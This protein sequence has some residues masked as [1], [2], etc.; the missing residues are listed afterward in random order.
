MK[1]TI[2]KTAVGTMVLGMCLSASAAAAEG[3]TITILNTKSELVDQFE[4]LAEEY[5]EKTGVNVEVSFT[6]DVVGT[7]LAEKYAAG[8]PYTVMMVDKPDVYDFQEYLLDLSGEKWAADG[9]MEYGTVID[10]ALY[11]FPLMIESVGLL[12]NADAIEAITGEPFV[13]EDYT[14]VEAFKQLLEELKAGGME[15]PVAVNKEDWSLANHFFGQLYSQQGNSA[16]GSQSFVDDLIAGTVSLEENARFQSIMDTFDLLAE[17]NINSSDPLAAE[18]DLNNSYFAEGDVAFWFNGSWATDIYEVTEN[19]GMMPMPQADTADEANTRLICGASKALVVDGS[20]STAEEQQAA[21]DFLNWLAY[22]E[23]GQSFIVD[24]CQMI[25]AF[26]HIEKTVSTP[27]G[28]SAQSFIQNGATEYWYQTIPGDHGT[29]VGASLQ[30]YL[31]GVT[32]RSEFAAEV[33]QY[34]AAQK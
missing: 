25:P 2:C 3:T 34:W 21:K 26:S 24:S 4:A 28:I 16:E 5:E 7:H 12:Y 14:D 6:S 27:L 10:G 18:Y 32:E 23:D 30:K 33:E 11:S 9:G 15:K 8:T 19:I 20:A 22:E 31:A 1:K 17:Y 29:Q 13:W